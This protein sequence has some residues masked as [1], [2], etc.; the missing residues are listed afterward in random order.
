MSLTDEK[1]LTARALTKKDLDEQIAQVGAELFGAD[2]AG[3]DCA[4]VAISSADYVLRM[5]RF[6]VYN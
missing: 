2:V 3:R 1:T 6:M 4:P 5:R